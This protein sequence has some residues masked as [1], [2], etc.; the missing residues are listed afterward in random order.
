MCSTITNVNTPG[1]SATLALP[2]GDL[3]IAG[4]FTGIDGV[5]ANNLARWS[6]GA[7]T[8]FGMGLGSAGGIQSL[9]RL[10]N[11]DLVA[12]GP[13]LLGGATMARW[14]G[15]VWSPFADSPNFSVFGLTV[16]PNGDLV[17]AGDFTAIG[18]VPALGV[19]RWDGT[20]W[21]QLAS[22][23]GALG[24]GNLDVLAAVS[25][26]NG[27]LVVGGRFT[28]IGGILAQRIA[29]WNGSTWSSIGAGLPGEVWCLGVLP[30]GDLLAGGLGGVF[31]W[32]GGNWSTLLAL[33][34]VTRLTVLANGDVWVAGGAGGSSLRWWNGTTWS[35]IPF[36]GLLVNAI[37]QLPNG[38]VVIGGWFN[39]VGGVPANHIARWDGATWSAFGGGTN[40]AVGSLALMPDGSLVAA[41]IFNLAGGIA[42]DRAARWDGVTW[43]PLGTPPSGLGLLLPLPNGDLLA[44]RRTTFGGVTQ[45]DR[46][47]GSA[48]SSFGAGC[49]DAVYGM[50]A[51]ANGEVVVHGAFLSAGGTASARLARFASTCP[52]SAVS[53]GAG[54]TGSAGPNVLTA[55]S[56]PWLG[57]TFRTVGTGLPATANVYAVVGLSP[58]T[59]GIDLS[60]V[61]P[62]ALAGC[63]LHVNPDAIV[64]LGAA[65]GSVEI[66]MPLPNTPSLAGAA[67]QQQL[68][69]AETGVGGA[70]TAITVTNALDL[71][72]GFF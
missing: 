41:G 52:A 47:D 8:P 71:V 21:S 12:G 17:A 27:D 68:V 66:D 49:D 25:M 48:W 64:G 16:L 50:L 32:S 35:T 11:G 19:A 29:R 30:N 2:N 62:E 26:P 4:S 42:V 36:S 31:L 37:T 9:A 59:G 13:S 63:V 53:S 28:T 51:R 40:G 33:S 22:G 15:S 24:G 44:S 58:A 10:P 7:W 6:N 3:V 54:C 18:T 55:A 43:S 20:N 39:S 57:S 69:V 5:A 70:I 67:F 34:T 65:A 46:W 60:Q 61:F 38:D 14:N 72:A 56:L 45:F 1:V 23:A